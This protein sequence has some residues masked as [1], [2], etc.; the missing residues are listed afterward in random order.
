MWAGGPPSHA[1]NDMSDPVTV[2]WGIALELLSQYLKTYKVSTNP[3]SLLLD[4]QNLI[5]G[6]RL[7][8]SARSCRQ[9]S[10]SLCS[11]SFSFTLGLWASL[12]RTLPSSLTALLSIASTFHPDQFAAIMILQLLLG[13]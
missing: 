9:D 13:S 11:T 10:R 4:I 1:P 12:M 5:H 8:V 7:T 3:G 2:A 6:T